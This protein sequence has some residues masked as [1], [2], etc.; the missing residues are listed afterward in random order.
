MVE[1]FETW[2]ELHNLVRR[3]KRLASKVMGGTKSHTIA[4]WK[5]YVKDCRKLKRDAVAEYNRKYGRYAVKIHEIKG[6]IQ[7]KKRESFLL[8]V[9]N[10]RK[11]S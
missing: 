9:R 11:H 10:E 6:K 1:A 2:I 8:F 4:V 3:M 5:Q 7:E